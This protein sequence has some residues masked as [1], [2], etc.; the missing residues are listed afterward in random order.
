MFCGTPEGVMLQESRFLAHLTAATSC[1]ID[2]TTLTLRGSG[3]ESLLV[4]RE[5]TV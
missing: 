4:F 2:G 5:R 1:S 3:G